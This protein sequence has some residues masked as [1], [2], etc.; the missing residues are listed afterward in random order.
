MRHGQLYL[1][2]AHDARAVLHARAPQRPRVVRLHATADRDDELG[3][4]W[5]RCDGVFVRRLRVDDAR[6]HVRLE[7]ANLRRD[8]KT[9]TCQ[10]N[11]DQESL[12][13]WYEI[14]HVENSNNTKMKGLVASEEY[15]QKD[16]D[17]QRTLNEPRSQ[18]VTVPSRS[19]SLATV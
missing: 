18:T 8:E 10:H 7:I 3:R 15:M 13:R 11:V 6:G 12:S 14:R 19:R 1:A 2:K 9:G 4:R 5:Q 16:D 17:T